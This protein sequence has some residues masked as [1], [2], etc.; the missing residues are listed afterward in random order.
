[1]SRRPWYRI[2]PLLVACTAVA[3]VIGTVSVAAATV[4]TWVG[5]ASASWATA[6]SWSP[7]RTVPATSD[8]LQFNSGGSVTATSV[9]TQTV[10]GL[11]V[12]G[13]TTVALQ[14][15]AG[16]IVLTVSG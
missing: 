16:L 15:A 10:A 9:P 1:M 8:I 2:R 11:S 6:A 12:S 4:Y 5:G 13:S 14:P 7:A 3:L